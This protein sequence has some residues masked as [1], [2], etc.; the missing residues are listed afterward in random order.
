M[1]FYVLF[2]TPSGVLKKI[3]N[4]EYGFNLYG[5]G[6][7]Y[8]IRTVYIRTTLPMLPLAGKFAYRSP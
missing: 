1:L 8:K 7:A 5:V 4:T 2:E 6:C 3:S